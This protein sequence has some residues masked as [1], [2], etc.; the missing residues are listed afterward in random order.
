MPKSKS[1]HSSLSDTFYWHDYE[2][3][4]A[5]PAKDRPCQFA[6]LRTDANLNVIGDP[7]VVY[8]RPTPDYLPNPMA[9]LVTGITPQEALQKGLSE[10]EFITRIHAELS[11][12]LTCGVGYNS[13]RFD[14]EVTRHTLYRNFF[15]PYGR[16]YQDGNSRW[17]LIDLVRASYALRPEGIEWPMSED[18]FMSAKLERLTAANGIEHAGAH[19]AL[20]D[21]KATI[22]LAKLI[23][24]KQPKLFEYYLGLRFKRAAQDQLA[25]GQWRPIL[26]VSGMFG[27]RHA[28][29]GLVVPAIQHPTN[30]N[31]IITIDLSQSPEK[32]LDYSA[33]ELRQRLYTPADQLDGER[34]ALKSIHINRAPFVAPA[35]M[36]TDEVAARANLDLVA[37]RENMKALQALVKER[38]NELLALLRDVYAHKRVA[39]PTDP[40]WDLYGGFLSDGDR[41][42]CDQIK[43]ASPQILARSSFPFEDRRLGELLFRYRARNFPDTLSLDEKMQWQEY[44][45]ERIT[46][47]DQ[48][49]MHMERLFEEIAVIRQVSDDDPRAMQLM[50]ALESYSDTLLAL[51]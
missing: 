3:F 30:K 26:H 36:M 15:D 5:S 41:R 34:P 49:L 46:R 6:G 1:R 43:S 25:L 19:D 38:G 37:L 39:E 51:E 18:G 40:E 16:E 45:F 10:R 11:Q 35:K 28:N 23:K 21:V 50:D 8:S 44:C 4:G 9:I 20:V 48:G 33:D 32:L 42:L 12:P 17:D 27:A 13:L 47:E 7:L 2:T 14:D 29:I 22:E 24:T 31:E